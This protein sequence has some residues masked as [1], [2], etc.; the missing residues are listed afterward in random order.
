MAEVDSTITRCSVVENLY[1]DSVALMQLS[2]KISSM[3]GVAQASAIVASETNLDLLRNSGLLDESCEAG[4]SDV[5]IAVEGSGEDTVA[6]ALAQARSLLLDKQTPAGTQRE[7]RPPTS[8]ASAI[9]RDAESNF[10]LISTPGDYAASEAMK[11]LKQGLNVMLFSDNVSEKDEIGLK[12]YGKEHDLLV[13]GPDCGTAIINGVPLAFANVVKRGT[14]GV[15]AASGTGLQQVTSLIDRYGMGVS[16]AIGT[17]GHDLHESVG[18]ITM[19]QAF[20]ALHDDPG[21][22]IIV[23]VSKPPAP[24]V[25]EKIIKI[26][27]KSKKPVVINF[28]SPDGVRRSDG[29]IHLV[30][31]LEDAARAAVAIA[32][33]DE[34]AEVPAVPDT[35]ASELKAKSK[36]LGTGRYVR[37]LFSGGTF[38]Y[39]ALILF[40]EVVGPAYSNIAI[41]SAY[42][43]ND[44]WQ[45]REHC[46]VD[47]GDDDFTRGRPHPM[48]DHRLRNERIIKE[49]EDPETAVI[50]LDIVLGYGSHADPATEMT[51]A[52]AAALAA[53]HRAA[54]DRE[55]VFI[56]SVCGTDG[57]PQNLKAQGS[58][59]REAGV[60][61][62]ESNAQAALW[63]A[64]VVKG[65]V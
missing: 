23:L 2:S 54:G 8:I 6:A 12:Q 35:I 10:V 24:S 45:S 51:P 62:A 60:L 22:D 27:G 49:A 37:G 52:L 17:G 55:I 13:M 19:L 48:I 57:D 43:L 50:L 38:C 46:M 28:L 58:A 41:D 31:T 26:A 30:K 44:V 1:R 39:E 34:F 16:Q 47:L 56:G 15:I 64:E 21:T 25:A 32:R 14:I 42:K 59:L 4:P 36:R 33:G 18:G 11:A 3:E 7:E 40:S 9:R 61:L 65:V 63:A 5:L 20:E 29:N 53:A